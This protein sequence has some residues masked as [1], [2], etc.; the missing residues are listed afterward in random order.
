[1]EA[2]EEILMSNFFL[3]TF[4][5]VCFLSF[6]PASA[7]E[8]ITTPILISAPNFRDI[9]GISISNGGSGL[10]N[11]TSKDGVMRT[12]VFYRTDLLGNLN[13]ANFTTISSLGIVRDI[14]LRT[15]KEIKDNRDLLP[16][17]AIYTNVNIIGKEELPPIFTKFTPPPSQEFVL[18]TFQNGYKD[19]V[20]DPTVRAGFGTVL[21]TLA[22]DN[23][24]DLFHCSSGKDRTGWTAALLESIA[25]AS[26]TTIMKDYLASNTTLANVIRFQAQKYFTQPTE[27]SETYFNQLFGVDSTY[28]QASLD[29]VIASYGSMYAYLTQGLGL[30]QADIYVLRAKMVY[31]QSLPGQ[32]GFTGNAASGAA[33][34]N[35]LQ[36]SPLSRNY[37]AYNFYLQSAV[38]AGTLGGVQ[39]RVGGQVHADATS[40]LL[41]QPLLIDQFLAPYT[42]GSDLREGQTRVWLAGLVG[43][44]SS[45]G[46][47]GIAGSTENSTGSVFGAT[48]RMNN[49]ASANLG[50]GYNWGS[51]GSADATANINTVLFT[52][53]GRYGFSALE[54]GP[55]VEARADA[56]SV[57]YQSRRALGTDLGT[58]T[59]NTNGATYSGKVGLG[60][61]ITL[62]PFTVMLQTGVR[63]ASISLRSFNENGSDMAL[64]VHDI[65]KTLTSLLVDLNVSLD[66]KQL[67]AWTIAPTVT[68]GY[69]RVLSNTQAESIGTLYDF[70]VT[71]NAAYS[72]LNLM[73]TGLSLS[74][75][76]DAFNV[77]AGFNAV[78]GDE[79]KSTGLGGELSLGYSF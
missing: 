79:G 30:T 41:R 11:L 68:L 16:A 78:V 36:N 39:T 6:K 2:I 49:H 9:A 15:P 58:P 12:G 62:A 29:Q 57:D 51:V 50:I 74:A 3:Y 4:S 34:L 47:S 32:S 56:G 71:Q 33:L 46:H 13:N 43:N 54:A 53:G 5:V 52:I 67:G 25:G 70:D 10:V 18:T 14:D 35:A 37:T 59:G 77:K 55:F 7:Q 21:N 66:R 26:P 42:S 75:K 28:L 65:N 40:Y 23:G 38:D 31:Y 64:N 19:F 63:L 76:H 20:T 73:K 60:D 69:E 61:V 17:G 27:F 45:D 44:F 72:S 48:Y 1:M 22:H 8:T 24:P